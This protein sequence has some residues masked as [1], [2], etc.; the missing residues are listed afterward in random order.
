MLIGLGR[1][2]AC[3]GLALLLMFT[4]SFIG[5]AVTGPTV[6]A[7]ETTVV[8]LGVV[9]LLLALA[10]LGR[11]AAGTRDF[12]AGFGRVVWTIVCAGLL[13]LVT[14]GMFILSVMGLDR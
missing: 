6:S 12:A 4:A 1:L 9:D 8:V 2:C 14:V 13:G 5:I 7:A 10:L 3:C 11:F